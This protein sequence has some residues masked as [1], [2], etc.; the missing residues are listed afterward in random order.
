M[1][2]SIRFRSGAA[3]LLLIF[4]APLAAQTP[5]QQQSLEALLELPKLDSS[6][7][8]AALK[9]D[10]TKVLVVMDAI[11]TLTRLTINYDANIPELEKACSVD[12]VNAPVS[13]VLEKVLRAN[14]IGYTVLSPRQLLVY[15]DTPANREKYAW[16]VRTF[17]V[18]HA[19]PAELTALLYRQ[20]MTG[21]GIRP[22]I[23]ADK[24][25][26]TIKVRATGDKLAV[27]AKLI[28][29]ND[30]QLASLDSRIGPAARQKYAAVT[31]MKDWLNP[32]VTVCL[33]GVE[34]R[35]TAINHKSLV[36]PA[37]LRAALVKLPI[38]A[39]PYGRVVALQ[40]C[41]L[42]LPG[43]EVGS[44][45]RLGQVENVLKAL[46]VEIFGVPAGE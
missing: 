36:T 37:D 34:L 18:A 45:Q 44:R 20:L 14:G 5:A 41:S 32:Y 6:I 31:D 8:I 25:A 26:H 22:I 27:I 16:S 38:E 7:R 15:S 9:R 23:V 21:Q 28:A 30:K 12:F 19:D 42:G 11:T 43:D 35:A 39:W 10:A 3:A 33:Q 46:G 1:S 24:T 29:E 13:E 2:P 4:V 40:E 17:P